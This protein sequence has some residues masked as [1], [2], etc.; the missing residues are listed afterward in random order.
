MAPNPDLMTTGEVANLLDV[1][2]STVTRWVKNGVLSA[3]VMPS[4][5]NKFRRADIEALLDRP[6]PP[7]ADEVA[8]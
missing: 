5:R 3:V 6:E 4:G 2:P 8:S 1:S 7:T